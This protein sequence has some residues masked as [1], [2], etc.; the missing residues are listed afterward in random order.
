MA[1]KR[2]IGVDIGGQHIRAGRVRKG[3]VERFI[4]T[5]TEPDRGQQAV[6]DN[7]T[8]AIR[9]AAEGNDINLIGIG[10]PGGPIDH[11]KGIIHRGVNLPFRDL[12]IVKQFSKLFNAEVRLDN[13][14]NAFA[15]GEAAYGAGR[16]YRLVAG[17]TLG[18]GL[19]SGIVTGG[20]IEH[21]RG[22]AGEA[23]HMKLN[24][25]ASDARTCSCGRKGCVEAYVSAKGI[26][27]TA[28][29]R[30]LRVRDPEELYELA[31][32][33]DKKAA[34][35]W[36]ETGKHLGAGI[37]SMINLIDPDAIVIGG[38]VSKAWKFFSSSMKEYAA[39][40]S[41][42]DKRPRIRKA[43]LN[44]SAIIGAAHL[45]EGQQ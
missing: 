7:I 8:R 30:G 2:V 39:S 24:Y 12:N 42:S 19:G 32:Q 3:N 13:D 41:L 38:N 18:T 17:I 27:Q 23:G 40:E 37:S 6:L 29:E 14:A 28:K 26:V 1:S 4:T 5:P 35:A 15:L 10:C 43:K 33:D 36:D 21:G 25:L 34:E 44:H 9:D 31:K 16:G 11:E 20:R 45:F 22:N